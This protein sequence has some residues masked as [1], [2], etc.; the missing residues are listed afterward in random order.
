MGNT[1]LNAS[2]LRSQVHIKSASKILIDQ[3]VTLGQLAGL[4]RFAWG[5][6]A[7]ASPG[8]RSQNLAGSAGRDSS[9]VKAPRPEATTPA[10]G[11]GDKAAIGLADW[12]GRTLRR[13]RRSEAR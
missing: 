1:K 8:G 11:S 13:G 2:Q 9:V 10:R 4:G 6:E 5:A 7:S 3:G 12:S